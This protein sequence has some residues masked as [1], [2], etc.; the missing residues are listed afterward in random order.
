MNFNEKLKHFRKE[1]GYT[2][3][4]LADITGFARSTITELESG[5][6]K[7]TL[8]TIEKIANKTKTNLSDWITTDYDY[9]IKPFDGLKMVLDALK[10]TGNIDANGN[11]NDEA[12][13]LSMKMLEKEVKLLFYKKD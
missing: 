10:E 12:K 6:K 8:K 4:Q 5:K 13:I 11:M 3:E 2:Q 9:A 7:A 1:H